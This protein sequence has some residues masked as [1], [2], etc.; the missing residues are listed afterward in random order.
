MDALVLERPKLKWVRLYLVIALMMAAW[1]TFAIPV[2]ADY[3]SGQDHSGYVSIGSATTNSLLLIGTSTTTG[4][5]KSISQNAITA[6]SITA[7][8]ASSTTLTS[9]RLNAT[10]VGDGGDTSV[11]V[12]FGIGTASLSAANFD[13]YTSISAWVS[14]YHNGSTAY[15]DKTGLGLSTTYYYRAQVKS[16]YGTVTSTNEISFTTSSTIGNALNLRGTPSNTSIILT[17]QKA[18]ASTNTIIRYRTDT[19]PSSTTD[20]TSV[21]SG[22]AY[23]CTASGLTAGQVYYFRAWG[24]ANPTSSTTSDLA[25]STLLYAP[26]TGAEDT[27]SNITPNPSIPAVANQ[28][29]DISGLNLEPFTSMIKHFNTGLGMPIENTWQLLAMLG[30]VVAGIGTYIKIKNFFVA[31][32]VVFLLTVVF[33]GLNLAQGYLVILE[34]IVGAGV[35]AIERYMQ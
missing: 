25:M 9:A 8:A 2:Y 18:S 35:W 24:Y 22:T 34:L 28:A 5:Y 1:L 31:Y 30:L 27:P 12:R 32:F 17:W 26:S 15:L 20:G 11:D 23:Q 6:P 13:S 10:V 21:Y 29:P 4:S 19:Y 16:T 3:F 33:V 7:V 14:G